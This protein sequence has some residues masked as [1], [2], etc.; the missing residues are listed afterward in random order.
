MGSTV[1]RDKDGSL[2]HFG[3]AN[4]PL[5]RACSE[6]SRRQHLARFNYEQQ[7]AEVAAWIQAQCAAQQLPLSIPNSPSWS[8]A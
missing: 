7:F 2:V 4:E 1:F 8:A 6:N 3:Y 5:R